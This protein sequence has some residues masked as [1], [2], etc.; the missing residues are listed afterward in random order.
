MHVL[1]VSFLLVIADA[2]DPVKGEIAE[3][4]IVSSKE[5]NLVEEGSN[6]IDYKPSRK[7]KFQPNVAESTKKQ[8]LRFPL[9]LKIKS[10]L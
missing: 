10:F 1:V 2:Y 5:R 3:L 9:D 8:F 4:N 6:Y 7:L